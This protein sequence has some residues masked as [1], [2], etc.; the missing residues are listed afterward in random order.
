[1][2]KTIILFFILFKKYSKHFLQL[3]SLQKASDNLY[4]NAL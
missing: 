3:K 4:K 1:M 2:L